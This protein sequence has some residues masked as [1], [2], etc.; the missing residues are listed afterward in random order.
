[1]DQL[2]YKHKGRKMIKN[3]LKNKKNMWVPISSTDKISDG[4]IGWNSL[5]N[6]KIKRYLF[7]GFFSSHMVNIVNWIIYC[8]FISLIS[9]IVDN[10][11][12]WLLDRISSCNNLVRLYIPE[13]IVKNSKK[14]L[15]ILVKKKKKNF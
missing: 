14:N 10:I 6:K 15:N 4:F 13:K 3:H 12:D 8:E 11:R 5:K 9:L 2:V 7:I 1:M